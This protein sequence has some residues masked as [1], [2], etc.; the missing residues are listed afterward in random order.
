MEMIIFQNYYLKKL[1]FLT[2]FYRLTF[3]LNKQ[4]NKAENGN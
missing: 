4:S 3:F 2:I 1:T